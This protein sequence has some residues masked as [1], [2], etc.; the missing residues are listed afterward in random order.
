MCIR[1]R[2]TPF[3]TRKIKISL[4]ISFPLFSNIFNPF[5]IFYGSSMLVFFVLYM[6]LSF[7]LRKL[8]FFL[9]NYIAIISPS[10]KAWDMKCSKFNHAK[11]VCARW[12]D[13]PYFPFRFRFHVARRMS[14]PFWIEI[15]CRSDMVMMMMKTVFERKLLQQQSRSSLLSLYKSRGFN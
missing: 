12:V 3:H 10:M 2:T 1:I 7:I 4:F 5:C 13:S 15:L 9:E 14:R 8:L 11:V 6:F